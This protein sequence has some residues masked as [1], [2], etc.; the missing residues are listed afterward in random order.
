MSGAEARS[1]EAS[2]P[3][4]GY[5]AL[6]EFSPFAPQPRVLSDRLGREYFT[7]QPFVYRARVRF[8]ELARGAARCSGLTTFRQATEPRELCFA[9]R[10]AGGDEDSAK[11]LDGHPVHRDY[12]TRLPD[13]RDR[14]HYAGAALS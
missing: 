8:P 7:C 5:M 11:K 1:A 9:G 3:L 13:T 12:F 10:R 4:A 2:A 6:V 14:R